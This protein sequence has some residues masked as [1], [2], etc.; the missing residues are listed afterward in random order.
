MPDRTITFLT[1]AAGMIFA[2]YIVLVITTIVFATAQT[3]LAVEVR[4]TEGTIS[5]LET[6]YYAQV[7]K[8]DASSPA[9]VG[10]VKPA[11]VQYAIAKPASGLSFAGK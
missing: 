6:T 4:D 7:A 3:S 10:L 2:L 11:D 5:S 9:S 1:L 8:D